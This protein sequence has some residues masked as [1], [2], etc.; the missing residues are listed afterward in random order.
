[1]TE[2][3]AQEQSRT[4]PLLEDFIT[5]HLDD[6]L[7][8]DVLAFL[9]YCKTKKISYKWSSTNTWTMKSK[10]KSIGLI[11]VSDGNWTVGVGFVELIQYD[12]FIVKE[13]LQYDILN[14]LRRC[15]NCNPYCTPGYNETILGKQHRNLCRAMYFLDEKTCINC[16]N[17]NAEEI[18][19]IQRMIDFRLSISHG[20]SNRPIFDTK[21]NGLTRID[22]YSCIV[23]VTDLHGNPI[24]N[25]I[26]SRSGI[27]NL[28]DGKFD[29]YTRFWTNE[30][31]YEIMLRLNKP[32]AISMYGFV[33]AAT[34][35]IL[36][37]WKLYGAESL[38]GSWFMLDE[39]DSFPKPITSYTEKAFMIETSGAYQFYRFAFSKCKFDLS[40]IHIYTR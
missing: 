21:T 30:N 38:N 29:T 35:Q 4:K 27:N 1:M 28:F 20:T 6:R 19:R 7:Q 15:T 33:T 34:L 24:V 25:Q 13:N 3:L 36:G 40:Q 39:Q 17:P 37:S 8:Q 31:S 9:S 32:I 11:S 18:D 26:T 22:N 10:G 12:D 5:I 14:K 16:K 2:T 23:D